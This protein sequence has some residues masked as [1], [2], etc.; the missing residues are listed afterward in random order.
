MAQIQREG[1]FFRSKL[2]RRDVSSRWT[3]Q[4]W[5]GQPCRK[6]SLQVTAAYYGAHPSGFTADLPCICQQ[7][8]EFKRRNVPSSRILRLGDT[9]SAIPLP[10]CGLRANGRRL[11]AFRPLAG[12][13]RR[14]YVLLINAQKVAASVIPHYFSFFQRKEPSP[15]LTL[16]W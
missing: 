12:I 16:S 10:P 5:S 8:I 6:V 13:I 4:K 15:Q 3:L 1:R 11:R 14:K 9:L 7:P 2:T